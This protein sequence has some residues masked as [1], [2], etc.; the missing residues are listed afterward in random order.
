MR[1][2]KRSESGPDRFCRMC[3]KLLVR[4]LGMSTVRWQ[5]TRFCSLTCRLNHQKLE[6]KRRYYKIDRTIGF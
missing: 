4:P 3:T 6:A 1:G 5:K 2:R